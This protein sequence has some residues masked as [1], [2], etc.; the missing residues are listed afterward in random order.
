MPTHPPEHF[1]LLLPTDHFGSLILQICDITWKKGENYIKSRFKFVFTL[2]RKLT[3][4]IKKVCKNQEVV[5]FSVV[6]LDLLI[7]SAAL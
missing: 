5:V 7:S 3:E 1:G 4:K 2:E 6:R